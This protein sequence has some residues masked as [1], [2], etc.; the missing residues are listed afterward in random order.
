MTKHNIQLNT[1]KDCLQFLEWLNGDKS[2]QREVA[3]E[4]GKRIK[5]YY[6]ADF[7]REHTIE[8]ALSTFLGHAS[9]F[10]TRLCNNPQPWAHGRESAEQICNALLECTP[11]FLAVMYFLWYNVDPSFSQL[12]GGGWKQN[13]TGALTGSYWHKNSGGDLDQYLFAKSGDSKHGVIPGGFTSDDEVIYNAT[14]LDRGYPQ[15]Y[16]MAGDLQKIVDKKNYNYFRSVFVSSVIGESAKRPENAANSLVLARTFCD[17]VLGEEDHEKGGS[18]ITALN[19]SLK[20]FNKSICWKDLRDHCTK[21]K[22]RFKKIFA[23]KHF[24]FTG[25]S[26]NTGNLNKTALAQKTADWLRT[27]ITN[28]Q[29]H[30]VKIEQHKA[31]QH[32]GEYFTKNLFPYGFTI[33]NSTRFDM[34]PS[35]IDTLK[36]DWRDVINEFKKTDGDLN[37]LREILSGTYNVSC[38]NQDPP[39]EKKAEGA[40]NQ[41]KKAEAAKPT[42]TKTEVTKPVVTSPEATPNQNNGQNGESSSGTPVVKSTAP[43]PSPGKDGASGPK[44][45]PGPQG[46]PGSQGPPG[47]NGTGSTNHS[48]PQVQI[49]QNAVQPQQPNTVLPVL[50][51]SAPGGTGHTA[52]PGDPGA[53]SPGGDGQGAQPGGSPVTS[54]TQPTSASDSQPG[55]TGGQGASHPGGQDVSQTT[56]QDTDNTSSSVAITSVTTVSGGGGSGVGGG[57]GSGSP[58]DPAALSPIPAKSAAPKCGAGQ[59]LV[60]NWHDAN[61][62]CVP[63]SRSPTP[64]RAVTEDVLRKMWDAHNTQLLHNNPLQHPDPQDNHIV[65]SQDLSRSPTHSPKPAGHFPGARL[66]TPQPHTADYLG[67]EPVPEPFPP[68]SPSL[69]GSTVKYEGNPE[70]QQTYEGLYNQK[71]QDILDAQVGQRIAMTN[72]E[73]REHE[74]IEKQQREGEDKLRRH[75]QMQHGEILDGLK[76]TIPKYSPKLPDIGA[77]TGGKLSKNNYP[78]HTIPTVELDD[79][80]IANVSDISGAPIK[81]FRKT[82][83]NAKIPTDFG[84]LNPA[85]PETIGHTIPSPKRNHRMP[86]LPPT[87]R[88]PGRYT[89]PQLPATAVDPA[90]PLTSIPGASI[91]QFSDPSFQQM[92]DMSGDPVPGHNPATS[93]PPTKLDFPLPP[94]PLEIEPRKFPPSDNILKNENLIIPPHPVEFIDPA[95]PN[96]AYPNMDPDITA[97]DPTTWGKFQDYGFTITPNFDLCRNP[98]YVPDASDAPI[99]PPPS[100]PPD[101]SHMPPPDTVREMLYWMVGFNQYGLIGEIREYVGDILMKLNKDASQ[102][103]DSLDVTREPYNLTAS[104]VS[105]TLTEACNY[106]ASILHR[107]KHKDIFRQ[108]FQPLTSAQNIPSFITPPTPP[109][110]SASCGTT[111]TPAATS[112]RS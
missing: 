42:A 60:K 64:H 12:H 23:E 5:Q 17:I 55:P 106:A 111:P 14:L 91:S 81:H 47:P 63:K 108:T 86:P 8:S 73:K 101:S 76:I 96:E 102:P 85:I 36:K 50:P 2:M 40:Q 65:P 68:E 16:S 32:L 56:S 79:Q 98:W 107:I 83:Q 95:L 39:P 18:L 100:P 112:W 21:L 103:S 10:Y 31:N 28:V 61:I 44:G 11:K 67:G 9:H 87:F 13:W 93:V 94:H 24:D 75:T 54:P 29:G 58:Q 6:T 84:G 3:K 20:L 97:K 82:I 51:P 48:P 27:N 69:D 52:Q 105:Q 104:L 59:T 26:T 88:P 71:L 78:A 25:L 46:P 49:D 74:L 110:S 90:L 80:A 62:I 41:G 22:S 89:P 66:Q 45:A 33:F 77:T 92:M 30:L 38:K 1:L 19:E 70:L 57:G 72:I 43:A 4:L 7:L 37:T 34:F 35:D 109:A 53:G 15:G 99:Q